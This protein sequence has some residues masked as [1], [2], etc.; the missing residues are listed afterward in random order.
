MNLNDRKI[1][2]TAGGTIE[3][4][5]AV[6]YI[7]NFSSGKM[8]IAFVKNLLK[9]NKNIVLIHGNITVNLPKA[10]RNIY[11]QTVREMYDAVRRELT[12]N[13][14]LIMT[15]AVSDFKVKTFKKKKI[16]K[17]KKLV[18]ELIRTIDILKKLSKYK[19]KNNFFIGFAVES[20]NLIKNAKNKLNRKKL[21]MIIAN[22][23]D[24]KNNPFGSNYNK[25]TIITK[26]KIID[27]KRMKKE[28]IVKKIIRLLKEERTYEIS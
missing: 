8:G 14:L 11:T 16:K 26:D 18:L 1:I 20:S 3:P 25:V 7:G 2:I 10:S 23:I 9:I 21:D 15:A 5:D 6:R 17:Q 24:D 28:A 27:L 13:T 22:P 12:D 19:T 4:I